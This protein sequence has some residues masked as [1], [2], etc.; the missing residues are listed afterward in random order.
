MPDTVYENMDLP[1]TAEDDVTISWTSSDPEVISEQGVVIRTSTDRKVVLTAKICHGEV[2]KTQNYSVLV[3]ADADANLDAV[4][5]DLESILLNP[6]YDNDITLPEEGENGSHFTWSTSDEAVITAEGKVTRPAIGQEDAKVTLTV[7]AVKEEASA[8][9]A[10]EITIL[11]V[12]DTSTNEGKIK[13][14]SRARRAGYAD[15]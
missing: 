11:A 7:E 9:R 1:V 3:P 2:Q 4:T 14:H 15:L 8:S 12:P 13:V 10:F 6:E 5:K